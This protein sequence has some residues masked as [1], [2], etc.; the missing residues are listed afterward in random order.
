MLC[1]FK[2]LRRCKVLCAFKIHRGIEDIGKAWWIVKL[3][4]AILLTAR[5]LTTVLLTTRLLIAILLTTRLLIAILLTTRLLTA[6]LLT[7]R[8]LIA[9]LLTIIEAALVTVL[10]WLTPKS[11][12]I[13]V[14]LLRTE[15]SCK[16][17]LGSALSTKILLVAKGVLSAIGARRREAHQRT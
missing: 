2:I 14:L 10:K 13:I 7:T 15:R 5:L 8:L 11:L 9:V 6:V 17:L 12:L 4:V 16:A 1:A 3:L